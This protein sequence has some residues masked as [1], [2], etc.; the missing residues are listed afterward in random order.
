MQTILLTDRDLEQRVAAFEAAWHE[1]GCAEL[2]RFL[3]RRDDPE[4]PRVLAE[5][6]RVDLECRGARGES[7]RLLTHHPLAPDLFA[8]KCW[9]VELAF[10]EYRQRL[11]LGERR[12]PDEY[13]REYGIDVSDW[14][15]P[16]TP[17][18]FAFPETGDVLGSYRIISE[19]G[20]GSFGRVYLAEQIDLAGR[21][22]ALKVTSRGDFAEPETLA[23]LQHSNIVPIYSTQRI[24]SARLI[25]MPYLGSTT[26]ADVIEEL[27][28]LASW[29]SSGT[30][31]A[32]TLANRASRTKVNDVTSP[33]HESPMARAL[34]PRDQLRKYSHPEAVLWIG[35]K[36]ANA[37]AHAHDRGILHRDLKPANVLLTDDGEPMLLDFNLASDNS[38]V[39]DRRLGGT[40]AYMAPEQHAA[41]DAGSGT[42]DARADIYSLGLVLGE[43]LAGRA[44]TPD[45]ERD[46]RSRNPQVS[47]STESII[48]TC[49]QSDPDNRY[50]DAHALADELRRQL[51]GLPLRATHEPSLRERFTKWRK[52]HPVLAST[53][54]LATFA[55]LIVI[56]L[57][58]LIV[59][60]D[61]NLKSLANRDHAY[62]QWFE[63]RDTL[64][65]VYDAAAF[66][67]N[68]RSD[69]KIDDLL[70][71]YTTQTTPVEV[72]VAPFLSPADRKELMNSLGELMLLKSRRQAD[73]GEA[74]YWNQRAESV[75]RL[76]GDVPRT[77]WQDRHAIEMK[78]GR[79]QEAREAHD[80]AL[81]TD[82]RARDWYLSGLLAR[83]S[84]DYAEAA[85]L[86]EEAVSADQRHYWAWLLLGDART[87]LGQD[88][89]AEGCF[90]ACIALKPEW[91]M[92]YYNRG[93]CRH[94][95]GRYAE[96][97]RDFTSALD[98]GTDA[99][100][101]FLARGQSYSA[102]SEWDRAETDYTSAIELDTPSTRVYFLRA[103]ARVAKG[104]TVGAARDRAEG[105]RRIPNDEQS[106]V[107]R[108]LYRM[109]TGDF[110]G[111]ERDFEKAR[112]LN[113]SSYAAHMNLANLFDEHL[114]REGDAI[115]VLDELIMK[116]AHAMAARAGKAVL[117][118]R[119]GK[120]IAAVAEARWCEDRHPPREIRYQLAGVYALAFGF[121]SH[122][123]ERD[124]AL[125]LL[126]GALRDGY[127]WD[128]L[129]IDPDLKPLVREPEFQQLLE[130]AR[131]LKSQSRE[132]AGSRNR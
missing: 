10:E 7:P 64:P 54:S 126:R 95:L 37:L 32:D 105:L 43:L 68:S 111:A 106:W 1:A 51:H 5:L 45:H 121:S 30:A 129:A 73:S 15:E 83:E 59:E 108:G 84:G 4:F 101:A 42:V 46:I 58:A 109:R 60:R 80:R 61:R 104:D 110:R 92:A 26:L 102:Q 122:P 124:Q 6:I 27:H 74:L 16:D 55:L 91:A 115:R 14:P 70:E 130:S 67:R 100:T 33:E 49:L 65:A 69:Q 132:S 119:S 77:V 88:D 94:R 82:P 96:A 19:L 117:L 72:P 89:R 81:A 66:D 131:T 71:R 9:L 24:G 41:M 25:V 112:E 2:A 20:R 47:P 22:I 34:P 44:K 116:Q 93:L 120:A 39:H 76:T 87:H 128:L 63:F 99:A 28:R 107:M 97:G 86:F 127:G 79:E 50:A 18:G 13:A 53:V 62:R 52:R 36:L 31:L 90:N 78:R 12:T 11:E 114:H 75:F 85:S 118:A 48:R 40:P 29:P 57:I 21:L 103:D 113:P 56:L 3:P 38:V 125:M 17:A 35:W 8:D 98:R 123:A 23:R